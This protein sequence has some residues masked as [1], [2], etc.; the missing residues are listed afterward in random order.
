MISNENSRKSGIN[1]SRIFIK[2]GMNSK[3]I[4]KSLNK[5]SRCSR[6]NLNQEILNPNKK[7]P[8]N[9]RLSQKISHTS[10]IFSTNSLSNQTNRN[11]SSSHKQWEGAE[12]S[13]NEPMPTRLW[14]FYD[15]HNITNM[16]PIDHIK[17]INHISISFTDIVSTWAWR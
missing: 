15:N 11:N 8:L 16:T 1:I 17:Q 7:D 3:M 5:N 4:S 2:S 12:E 6:N 14:L 13:E 9:L 10:K